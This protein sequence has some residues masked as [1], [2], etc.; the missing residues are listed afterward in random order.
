[1]QAN[2]SMMILIT[3]I[4]AFIFKREQQSLA[5]LLFAKVTNSIKLFFHVTVKSDEVTAGSEPEV[6]TIV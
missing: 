4:V 6:A 1:M 2:D 3:G 5:G